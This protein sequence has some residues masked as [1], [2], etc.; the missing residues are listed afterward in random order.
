[1][2]LTQSTMM[3]LGATAPDFNLPSTDDTNVQLN[4]FSNAKALVVLFIC[5]HCPY[6]VH[7]APALS[8][9]AGE[10]QEQGIKFVAIS[11]ND[12]TSYPQDSFALMKKEKDLQQYPFPYLYDADQSVAKAYSAACTPDLYVF[13]SRQ[14]LVY[15]GEFDDTRPTRISSG[16]YNSEQSPAT[17][18]SLQKALKTLLAGEEIPRQQNASMG[19]NIKWIEGN[20][21]TYA[22]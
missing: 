17:G 19:C 1:M 5:N 11:S 7:I 22:G 20:E 8:S 21:P 15:R 13:N 9:L 6:V 12:A 16:N 4:D 14:E 3:K 2:S 10:L 18:A